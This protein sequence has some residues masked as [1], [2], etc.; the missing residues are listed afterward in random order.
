MDAHAAFFN[1]VDKRQVG[2][3]QVFKRGQEKNHVTL[4][5]G[6]AAYGAPHV[7]SS[8]QRFVIVEFETG[9]HRH[10][11]VRVQGLEGRQEQG[12]RLAG[13]DARIAF[14]D[15]FHV[16]FPDGSVRPFLAAVQT[17]ASR[18][19][20]GE[21][22]QSAVLLG[23]DGGSQVAVDVFFRERDG[24]VPVDGLFQDSGDIRGVF[25]LAEA[26]QED[27]FIDP[28]GALP[29]ISKRTLCVV[30]DT[31]QTGLVESKEILEK[32][33]KIA[34]ID[35]HRKGVGFIENAVL[36]CHEPYSSSTSE[37]VTEL[38]QYVGTREDKP[39]RVEAEGLLS[40]IML[41]TRDFTLHTGVRTFEAAA[42]L[43]RY[44]AETERVRQLFDVT[45]SEY[46]A[47]AALVAAAQMYKKCAISMSGELPSE[48]RVA[49]P[50]AAN[51]LLTI[52]GV[53]ASFV[54]VQVGSG[55][56]ISARSLGAVN[57]Q[58]IM[59]SL[60]GGGHQTMAAAQMRHITP[61]AAVSRLRSAIDTYR[62]SQRKDSVTQG[63]KA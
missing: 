39:N 55:V 59:E 4:R 42:A 46:N 24:G 49:I 22:C 7:D 57:V 2:L 63:T 18:R 47:K 1:Y 26:G 30:V 8:R 28:K 56:N 58:L 27:D 25:P 29:I 33:G 45:Q 11:I 21:D 20:G 12:N 61:E 60:G 19:V 10:V 51:D 9:L 50:Q 37:L 34:V 48:A 17:D 36:V 35:H 54:A 52:Q 13:V 44:G 3:K 62:A 23:M 43:R 31:Y 6:K 38:L 14:D 41:D 53:E 32:C 16:S 15:D 5:N 40:G